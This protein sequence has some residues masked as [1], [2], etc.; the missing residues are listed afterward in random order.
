[1]IHIN[2]SVKGEF[3]VPPITQL[4][5]YDNNSEKIF[6]AGADLIKERL[7]NNL[8]INLYETVLIYCVYIVSELR[9]GTSIS[10]IEE[11]AKQILTPTKVMI[12]V[13][14]SIQKIIFIVTIDGM[15]PQIVTLN[16]PIPISAYILVSKSEND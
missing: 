14:E 13:P 11:N 8:K 1:M 10:T 15:A 3:D 12:G 4:F 6:F 9:L 5:Q 7:K 2:A 16:K